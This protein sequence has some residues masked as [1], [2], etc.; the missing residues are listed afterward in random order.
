M[1]YKQGEYISPEKI[2][3]A[4]RTCSPIDQILIHG[5]SLKVC[6][7]TVNFEYT[8]YYLYIHIIYYIYTLYI[9][10]YICNYVIIIYNI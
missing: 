3:N 10:H 9:T 2:E 6:T 5:N 7:I 1:I 4:Y 8:A